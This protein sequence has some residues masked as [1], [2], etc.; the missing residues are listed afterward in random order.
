MLLKPFRWSKWSSLMRT[1]ARRKSQKINSW[2]RS[3]P[4]RINKLKPSG[5]NAMDVPKATAAI[6][7]IRKSEL[8]MS[9]LDRVCSERVH[10]NC[11]QVKWNAI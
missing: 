11:K 8:F 2:G 5:S 7:S 4:K 9:T 3:S 6:H 1:N 10:L